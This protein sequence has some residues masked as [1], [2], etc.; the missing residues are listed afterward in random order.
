ML[1]FK[2]LQAMRVMR[3]ALLY[4]QRVVEILCHQRGGV[5]T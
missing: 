1:A 4:G 2:A 5:F 3:C